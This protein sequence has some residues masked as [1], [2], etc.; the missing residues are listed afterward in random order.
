MDGHAETAFVDRTVGSF[1]GEIGLLHITEGVWDAA[2]AEATAKGFPYQRS[3]QAV[4]VNHRQLLCVDPLSY[5]ALPEPNADE[6]GEDDS[7]GYFEHEE[8]SHM[9]SEDRAAVTVEASSSSRLESYREV[10]R[11]TARLKDDLRS[12]TIE[13][14]DS[15]PLSYE[16]FTGPE[17][18]S[19]F[20][21]IQEAQS[22]PV[23]SDWNGSSSRRVPSPTPDSPNACL[24]SAAAVPST[25][26]VEDDTGEIESA[27]QA[28]SAS[29]T[30]PIAP[31][32]LSDELCANSSYPEMLHEGIRIT[33]QS[34]RLLGDVD[35]HHA[36]SIHDVA[37]EVGNFYLPLPFLL[38]S[39]PQRALGWRI[40]LEM[41]YGS[42]CAVKTFKDVRASTV[43]LHVIRT[44]SAADKNLDTEF[45]AIF[46][47]LREGTLPVE[48][49]MRLTVDLLLVE[50][51]PLSSNMR[52]LRLLSDIFTGAA[53]TDE[54]D[55]ERLL[56]A[57]VVMLRKWKD[58]GGGM[59]A[60]M[61]LLSRSSGEVTEL[62]LDIIKLMWQPTFTTEDLEMMLEFCLGSVEGKILA[63]FDESDSEDD[64]Y[65]SE[66]MEND[67]PGP[68][69]SNDNQELG[70][71]AMRNNAE[72][73]TLP[74]SGCNVLVPHHTPAD[75]EI[76]S[77][78]LHSR[79]TTTD[80]LCDQ[81]HENPSDLV[82]GQG[83]DDAA[84]LL[85]SADSHIFNDDYV[86]WF[87]AEI[88]EDVVR[89]LGIAGCD[90]SSP[91]AEE[92][93]S[94]DSSVRLQRPDGDGQSEAEDYA[95]R[96]VETKVKVLI[97]L[98]EL[99]VA[100]APDT[101][102]ELLRGAGGFQVRCPPSKFFTS[103]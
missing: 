100:K 44:R 79:G 69:E 6:L 5:A 54:L 7:L 13:S 3:L 88:D 38:L 10:Q 24:T 74:R 42:D 11:E 97:F 71:R 57:G 20:V 80:V 73:D 12:H 30:P 36:G 37:Q 55:R 61:D 9:I 15:L 102:V 22:K 47:M 34:I 89:D 48:D 26:P 83:C 21:V 28:A 60:A 41:L 59:V 90:F 68:M 2:S 52:Y 23:K 78:S 14:D 75:G 25:A 85:T 66:E 96:I 51:A 27:A 8:P 93:V 62:L 91:V 76:L 63:L 92:D 31:L 67:F 50:H 84:N 103:L 64:E 56:Q 33:G 65:N 40:L 82:Q 94:Q 70:G 53:G 46:E 95:A 29:A 77:D 16:P 35:I 18:F 1:C 17:Y 99:L 19:D 81:T 72:P 98:R 45:D 43:L 4:G 86:N 49:C 58:R 101:A 39:R 87:E 32:S